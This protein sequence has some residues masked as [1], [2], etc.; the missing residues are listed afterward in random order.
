M[1]GIHTHLFENN[2]AKI[3]NNNTPHTL[4]SIYISTNCVQIKKSY[5]VQGVYSACLDCSILIYGALLSCR[6]LPTSRRNVF[7]DRLLQ[8][9]VTT[10]E[11]IRHVIFHHFSFK[12]D[13]RCDMEQPITIAEWGQP[14]AEAF[15]FSL[16]D[17]ETRRLIG[18]VQCCHVSPFSRC[19]SGLNHLTRL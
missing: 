8:I 16:V 15:S 11:T 2:F 3:C 14:P 4:D 9:A 10:S 12:L 5:S 17:V 1:I 13:L 7:G 6:W 19:E 18:T